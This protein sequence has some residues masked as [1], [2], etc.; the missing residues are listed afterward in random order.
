MTEHNY[1]LAQVNIG[2]ILAPMDDPLMQ[3]FA[4]P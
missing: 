4:D 1:H 3:D 2:R